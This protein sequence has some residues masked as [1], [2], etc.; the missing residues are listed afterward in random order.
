MIRLNIIISPV[1]SLLWA[2][3]TVRLLKPFVIFLRESSQTSRQRNWSRGLLGKETAAGIIILMFI[4]LTLTFVVGTDFIA[5]PTTRNGPRVYTQ[6]Y[7]PT[8]IAASATNIIPSD[9]IR[10]WLDA[11]TW[12][13]ENLP[14]S[15]EKPGEP[16]TV[17]ASWWDYGYWITTIANRTTLADNGTWN[18]TQIKQIGLMFMSNETEA[19]K[20]LGRY[21]V[22]HVVVFT[23]FDTNGAFRSS[24][25]GDDGKWQW[26]AKIPGL[27]AT[28]FGN[29]SLGWDWFDVNGDGSYYD[30]SGSYET[31]EFF[32]NA[33]GQ[34]STI[35]KLMDYGKDMTLYGY[36]Y[37]TLEH[38]EKAYFSESEGAGSSAAI[39]GQ[40]SYVA[41]VCVYKVNYPT[42]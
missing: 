21:N 10:D 22:T 20:I 13:R 16:G 12:I 32:V 14:P 36:S 30:S 37:I 1:V 39:P 33:N 31:D 29:F 18:S 11:L 6:A 40:S 3:A 9:T 34:S 24:L 42:E 35:Y 28:S 25:G 27:D 7:T 23:T 4:L 26:M 19:L 2:F 38:F 17:I 41:L 5:P 15:P 8:Q